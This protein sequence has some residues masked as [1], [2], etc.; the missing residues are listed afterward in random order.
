MLICVRC[1]LFYHWALTPFFPFIASHQVFILLL[2]IK[3]CSWVLSRLDRPSSLSLSAQDRCS[4]LLMIFADF[5][6]DLLQ[7]VHNFLMLRRPE[8]DSILHTSPQLC[9]VELK[10]HFPGPVG[11]WDLPSGCITPSLSAR[12]QLGPHPS[13]Q[14]IF[15]KPLV[16]LYSPNFVSLPMGMLQETAPKTLTSTMC[17][18]KFLSE[19]EKSVTESSC[20]WSL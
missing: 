20:C 6:L 9:W 15:I 19:K 11:N 12:C 14:P 16:Q 2:L 3:N 10:D 18:N 17:T 8:L 7:Y 1:F 5:L 13:V 4:S